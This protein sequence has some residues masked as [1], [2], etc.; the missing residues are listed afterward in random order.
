MWW[1]KIELD[2]ALVKER[3]DFYK[4]VEKSNVRWIVLKNNVLDRWQK[5]ETLVFQKIS[6]ILQILT[7]FFRNKLQ[8]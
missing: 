6:G 1:V 3:T 7:T 2:Q 5:E 4:N 8:L